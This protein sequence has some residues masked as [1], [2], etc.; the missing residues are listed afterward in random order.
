MS[1]FY[2]STWQDNPEYDAEM[3]QIDPRP[4]T[5]T[6]T[7][8]GE[9]IRGATAGYYG[10]DYFDLPEANVHEECIS[11]YLIKFKREAR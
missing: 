6:C 10:D 11:D 5:L 2:R 1:R 9:A 3:S 8:C 7:H 4:R